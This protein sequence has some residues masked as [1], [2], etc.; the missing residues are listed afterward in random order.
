M[1]LYWL[2]SLEEQGALTLPPFLLTLQIEILV[3]EILGKEEVIIK[4]EMKSS[5]CHGSLFHFNNFF[6][7]RYFY[8]IIKAVVLDLF[9][10]MRH[11]V[12]I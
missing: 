2:G 1:V 11:G 6:L 8:L 5:F 3:E 7:P 9:F 12:I 10:L 4:K